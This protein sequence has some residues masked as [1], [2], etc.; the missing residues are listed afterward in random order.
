M[1]FS[2]FCIENTGLN[3]PCEWCQAKCGS[4]FL[5]KIK[6]N[7]FLSVMSAN[8]QTKSSSDCDE[9]LVHIGL[10]KGGYPVNIFFISPQKH[11]LWVLIRSASVPTT[12]TYVVVFIRSTSAR[13]F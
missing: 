6:E 5:L 2:F 4:Y 13:R 10:D 7:K 8:V 1:T 9:L 3:I 11:M 12:K